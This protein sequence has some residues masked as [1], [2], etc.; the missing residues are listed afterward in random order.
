MGW[1]HHPVSVTCVPFG[2]PVKQRVVLFYYFLGLVWEIWGKG[3]L[4][5]VFLDLNAYWNQITRSPTSTSSWYQMMANP[6][7]G[8][9]VISLD[10]FLFV[11]WGGGNPAI[12]SLIILV[13]KNPRVSRN[14][15]MCPSQCCFHCRFDVNHQPYSDAMEGRSKYVK[16]KNSLIF[17]PT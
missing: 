4:I 9:I 12:Y 6:N 10:M 8:A 7:A 2:G 17:G 15:W 5:V 11:F 13:H 14:S 3:G 1:N 16:T